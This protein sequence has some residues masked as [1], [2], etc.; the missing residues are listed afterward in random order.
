[1][2]APRG[3]DIRRLYLEGKGEKA[4]E[5]KITEALLSEHSAAFG[6]ESMEEEDR[7]EHFAAYLTVKRHFSETAFDPADFIVGDG[8]DTG[9]DAIAI[10]V[11]NNLVTDVHTIQEL[12]EINNFLDVTFVFV[13]AERS[14][15][16]ETKKLGQFGYGVSDFFGAGKLLRNDNI[17][18]YAEIMTTIFKHSSKFRPA[19]PSC[20]LYYVTNGKWSNDGD[21]KTRAEAVTQDLKETVMFSRVEFIPV[22]ADQIQKL[23]Y[24]SKNA[25]TREFIFDQKTFVPG[26]A[27]VKEAYLGFLPAQFLLNIVRDEDGSIIKSLFYENVRDWEGYNKINGE[28]KVTLSGPAK[29]RFVLMNNGVTII[30]RNLHTTGN[31]F[32]MTDF[33]IVNG[34]QTSNVLHD[35]SALID[36]SVRIPVRLIC[37]QDETVIESVITAT[38]SQTH[39][40]DDQFFA[41]KDFAKKLEIYFRTFGLE[42]RLYYERRSHQYDG[43]AIPASRIV[44]HT[45]LVR[46]VGAMFLGEPHITTRNFR[47]LSAKVGKEMFVEG[48]KLDPYYV[49]AFCLYTLEQLFK[50]TKIDKKYKAA[51]YQILLAVRLMMDPKPLPRMNSNE[52]AKRCE[53]MRQMLWNGKTAEKLFPAAVALVEKIADSEKGSNPSWTRD[54][55]RTEPVTKAIFESFHQ[56]YKNS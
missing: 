1:V 46:A 27:G 40:T 52:M 42:Q 50:Q 47:S 18:H 4:L 21:L 51:R 26:V 3:Y 14:P 17:K 20:Y 45:N 53:Q 41:M 11:N 15:H 54:T 43:T 19:N 30:A 25:I 23:Y 33:N 8:N 32:V 12:I 22:G 35:N 16:F 29:D 5:N 44:V 28:M 56:K 6:I 7:F 36:D 49:A 55:M 2:S 34:C 37:T 48:D 24:Q 9:I 10:I 38:N 39:V 31:K 13:Q